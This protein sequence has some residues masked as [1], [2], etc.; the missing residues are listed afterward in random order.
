[1]GLWSSNHKQKIWGDEMHAWPHFYTIRHGMQ[2][3]SM[4]IISAWPPIFVHPSTYNRRSSVQ[5]EIILHYLTRTIM[6]YSN[7]K[8]IIKQL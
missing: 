1:M 7:I 8:L 3:L 4:H 6:K 5:R 2:N